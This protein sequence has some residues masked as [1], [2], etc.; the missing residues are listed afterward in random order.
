NFY[1]GLSVSGGGF[2]YDDNK[3]LYAACDVGAWYRIPSVA[4]LKQVRFGLALQNLGK[5]FG[6]IGKVE[7][8]EVRSYP[9]MIT[10]KFG[11]AAHL[12]EVN[13]FVTGLSLDVGFP[14]FTNFLFNAGLQFQIMNI[15][16]LSVG[17]DFNA[18]EYIDEVH[19]ML[20]HIA[21]GVKFSVNTSG[22]ELFRRGGFDQTDIDIDLA[23][24]NA[25]K[26]TQVVSFGAAASFGVRDTIPPDIKIGEIRYE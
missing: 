9:A 4:F 22:N 8:F 3:D 18:R 5:T 11:V 20:P 16:F 19:S 25:H 21:L 15:A 13:N 1:L 7:D 2:W 6:T 24:K 17:W 23:W 14:T 26:D 12:V 10:P